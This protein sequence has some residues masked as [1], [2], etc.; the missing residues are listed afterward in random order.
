[1]IGSELIFVG[2]IPN[3]QKWP[4]SA[5]KWNCRAGK[6]NWNLGLGVMDVWCEFEKKIH[7]DL[8]ITLCFGSTWWYSTVSETAQ[9]ALYGTSGRDISL[10]NRP[11]FWRQN[12]EFANLSLKT[13]VFLANMSECWSPES[14]ACLF[15]H[16]NWIFWLK[17]GHIY[18]N[19]VF[20][21]AISL[22]L[23]ENRWNSYV[24]RSPRWFFDGHLGPKKKQCCIWNSAVS[25]SVISRLQCNWKHR[26]L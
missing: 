1:M 23:G 3:K 19:A 17:Y 15:F 4:P 18:I 26:G 20:S 14:F 8:D 13:H 7:W 24:G 22:T 21:I 16:L 5:Q 9:T 10:Y 11:C 12:Y 2:H 25:R 6:I